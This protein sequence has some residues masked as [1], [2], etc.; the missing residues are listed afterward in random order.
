MFVSLAASSSFSCS[1]V[2]D[3]VLYVL[4][5]IVTESRMLV[6]IEMGG[7]DCAAKAGIMSAKSVVFF[8]CFF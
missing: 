3:C 7:G 5:L 4:A 8:S 1:T 6:S 2:M